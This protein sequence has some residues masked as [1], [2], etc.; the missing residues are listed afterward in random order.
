MRLMSLLLTLN[1]LFGLGTPCLIPLFA[2]QGIEESCDLA[3]DHQGCNNEDE[4]GKT[5]DNCHCCDIIF[6]QGI[7]N[8]LAAYNLLTKNPPQSEY[9]LISNYT[10]SIWDPPPFNEIK[11]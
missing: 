7:S 3:D 2:N 6:S 8:A 5:C 10:C 9:A 1:I 4:T 11:S